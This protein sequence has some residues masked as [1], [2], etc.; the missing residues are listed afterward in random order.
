MD[1]HHIKLIALS[2]LLA[3]VSLTAV[4]QKNRLTV[5][6]VLLSAGSETAL[7]VS[8]DNTQDIVGV[9]FTLT[10][11]AGFSL[12]IPSLV[13]TERLTNHKV[14]ARKTGNYEYMFIV[15]SSANQP[16]SSI[17]GDLFAITLNAAGSVAG[18][19]TYDMVLSDV[20]MSLRGGE[21]VVEETVAGHIVVK[22]LPNLHVVAV[23][24]SEAVAGKDLT[25]QWTVRN[26][27]GDTE[28]QEWKDHVWLTPDI[29]A[30]NAEVSGRRLLAVVNN[31]VGLDAGASYDNSIT[32]TLPERIYGPYDIVVCSDMY[33]VGSIDLGPTGGTLPRPYEPETADY[34]FLYGSASGNRNNVSEEGESGGRSDNFFYQQINIGV[35]PLPDIVVD[36]A[37]IDSVFV[38]ET[39]HLVGIIETP[40][41]NAGMMRTG[42]MFDKSFYS[43]MGYYVGVKY[44]NRG[45]QTIKK[46]GVVNAIY[47]S[48][49]PDPTAEPLRLLE[50]GIDSIALAPGESDRWVK[51][52]D[53][54]LD[55]YGD[56]YFHVQIDV[57]DVIY[58]AANIGNNW[59]Y[60]DKIDVLL[61]PY[62][63]LEVKSAT[64]PEKVTA[65]EP[66]KFAYEVDNKGPGD[67]NKKAWDDKVYAT[68]HGSPLTEDSPCVAT[69]G[70]GKKSSGNSNSSSGSAGTAYGLVHSESGGSS[71]GGAIAV[72]EPETPPFTGYSRNVD[73][74]MKNFTPGIYD[75]YLKLDAENEMFEYDGE[76]NNTYGPITVQVEQ[77]DL[78]AQLLSISADTLVFKGKTAFSW[79]VSNQGEGELR[80]AKLTDYFY[81]AKDAS[82][83]DAILIGKDENTVSIA[84]G[85]EKTLMANLVIPDD[86]KLTGYQYVFV[87]TNDDK[88]IEEGK[89]QNNKS[90]TM[91]KFFISDAP[92][93]PTDS[94]PNLMVKTLTAPATVTPGGQVTLSYVVTNSG[95]SA[96]DKNVRQEVFVSKK[97]TFSLSESTP[98]TLSSQQA[99]LN[100]L[101]SGK[102]KTIRV[103]ATMPDNI[104]GGSCYLYVVL[105]RDGM[106]SESRSDDNRAGKNTYM[107]GNLPDLVIQD[108]QVPASVTTSTPT[109]VSWMLCNNGSWGAEENTVQVFLSSNGTSQDL[110]LTTLETRWLPKGNRVAMHT[111]LDIPDDKFGEWFL[112]LVTNPK[113]SM[114]ELSTDNNTATTPLHVVQAPLP[115]LQISLLSVEGRCRGGDIITV[116]A[117]VSN[118]GDD[119]THVDKWADAAYVT[120]GYTLENGKDQ[121]LASKAH[122]GKLA[123]GK[124]YTF[125]LSLKLPDYLSGYHV[126]HV[127]AD[128]TSAI[129]DKSRP[130]NTVRQ[131]LVV[132]PRQ[133]E[134]A[135][136]E[137][138]RVTTVAH[139]TAG[140]PVTIDYE[141]ANNGD[142]EADGTL[143]DAIYLSIDD[144]WDVDDILVGT[145]EGT[146]N[147][148]PG[149]T[150][151]R[152]A[153]GRIANVVE[154]R[155]HVIVRTNTTHGIFEDDYDNN[156]GVQTSTSTI[157]F[158]TLQPGATVNVNTAGYYKVPIQE[159]GTT[160]TLALQLKSPNSAQAG[161][162]V[163]YETVP[164]T[165]RYDYGTA[166][167]RSNDQQIILPHAQEGTYYVLAQANAYSG[168]GLYDFTLGDD[169]GSTS[170]VAMTLSAQEIPFGA[171]RLSVTEGGKDGWVTTG[172]QGALLDSIMDFRL[173][174]GDK[175]IPTEHL[176]FNNSSSTDVTFNLDQAELGVYD[177]LAELPDGTQATLK[178]AFRVV[179]TTYQG[180]GVKIEAPRS[181]RIGNYATV[182][183]SYSNTGT[184]D[185]IVRGFIFASKEGVIA[186]SFAGPQKGW[187]KEVTF[188]PEEQQNAI[189][190]FTIPPGKKGVMRCYFTT[191]VVLQPSHL[192]L[193]VV[194]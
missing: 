15:Y 64:V 165:A 168:Q 1:K 113:K 49:S 60:T 134:P 53:I 58:E 182:D 80:N 35:P 126:L 31:P 187:K 101:G 57:Q 7:H 96:V 115:D 166:D 189:G 183:V 85:G 52:V 63:D 132:E 37:V 114:E 154:G 34:G 2:S 42:Y 152:H 36:S 147:I 76:D 137:V 108:I 124:D 44:T 153:T 170:H 181:I 62:A 39:Y 78:A 112:L 145:V 193:Y 29:T 135:D 174:Q 111:Q 66:F 3:L 190:Y 194:K 19:K 28:S 86:E 25:I 160:S 171:S 24:C 105:N 74:T 173:I 69:I 175:V 47:L 20:V 43:F 120:D 61:A 188:Y 140:T 142:Y 169:G 87:V 186:T 192:Y 54:P 50:W 100:G 16:I 45:Y 41:Q 84:A 179:P 109:E 22:N 40:K 116:T 130:D 102:Q 176:V 159:E 97:Q 21:N 136:L 11:P 46:T 167:W 98:C 149:Q 118:I 70:Y 151:D 155:Y 90:N 127:C 9:Q 18:G 51:K 65:G 162:Y 104:Q 121:P 4:A 32:I 94:R 95:L 5:G 156:D 82:G 123:V 81:A 83:T 139:I 158:A 13:P 59:G 172:I 8:M 161:L 33:D 129:V 71:G 75:L 77:V 72:V 117:K 131:T 14:T 177:L 26:D 6:D 141:V 107:D 180:L 163:S 157:E 125:I 99:A 55:W 91:K 93:P 73:V 146:V 185:I 119:I 144:Q 191:N 48:H 184:R 103:T 110:L 79:K 92:P 38:P 23:D 122:V 178:K 89:R 12:D 56:T 164:T 128:P 68:P 10:L 138:A 88:R 106:L 27:G 148:L 17:G 67:P 150:L 143:H 133:G 30:G